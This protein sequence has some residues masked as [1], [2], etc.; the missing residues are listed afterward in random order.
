MADYF[1]TR[2]KVP[3]IP[4]GQFSTVIRPFT[5]AQA[6]QKRWGF[7]DFDP[8]PGLPSGRGTFMPVGYTQTPPPA[9][10][11]ESEWATPE[12]LKDFLIMVEGTRKPIAPEEVFKGLIGPTGGPL[13]AGVAKAG[14]KGSADPSTLR[15]NVF[16]GSPYKWA[17]EPKF[18]KG[19]PRLDKIGTGE[20]AQ[21]YGHGFYSADSPRVAETYRSSLTKLAE[22]LDLKNP[23]DRTV[24]L[25]KFQHPDKEIKEVLKKE[26]G[27]SSE[28]IDKWLKSGKIK[29]QDTGG[30][31][32]L[33][34]PD[35]DIDKYL[36]WD[37]PLSQQPKAVRD[38]F[39]F[40]EPADLPN[41]DELLKKV[42]ETGSDNPAFK[43]KV[44]D[45]NSIA[46]PTP[47][48]AVDAFYNNMENSLSRRG[49]SGKDAY[50]KLSRQLASQHND[51]TGQQ[52]ASEAL[53]K[54]G[55]PGLKYYDQMSRGKSG[56]KGTRNY[57][58]WDQR[59]LNRAK[60]LD[61]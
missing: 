60:I 31:Y 36:D 39:G 29:Y 30:F 17:A 55:I 5:A 4:K 9:A 59:V 58:T 54:A 51:P 53:R 34:I 35:K 33:D 45:P 1:T 12:L 52:A 16:H 61:E 6:A 50:T 11:I 27:G 18:P 32:K 40:K 23:I 43:Y 44:D 7:K 10:S 46:A 28:E 22:T 8:V 56:G 14:I 13:L 26:F 38:F 21:A 48:Q 49:V 19:R 57:V 15:V 3:N 47:K 2:A 20:G 42:V 24:G 41:K 25:I 37:A